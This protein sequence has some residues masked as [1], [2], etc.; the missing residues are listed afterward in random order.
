MYEAYIALCVV[1]V[2][3]RLT[4][5]GSRQLGYEASRF[6][7]VSVQGELLLCERGSSELRRYQYQGGEYKRTAATTLPQGM[8]SYCRK[9]TGVRRA[10]LQHWRED[11]VTVILGEKLQEEGRLQERGYLRG[12]LSDDAPVHAQRRGTDGG[13]VLCVTGS[14]QQTVLTPPERGWGGHWLSVCS[15]G[16]CLVVTSM[17]DRV[18][19]VFSTTGES[20]NYM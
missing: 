12:C 15:T 4:P 9:E 14:E 20:N 6:V 2:T 3:V 19:D 10:F 16:H 8:D 7:G 1:F 17:E 11:A 13:W 5:A 18:L